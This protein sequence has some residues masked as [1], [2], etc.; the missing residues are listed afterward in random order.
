MTQTMLDIK[1]SGRQV[2]ALSCAF[3]PAEMK[4]RMT[5]MVTMNQLMSAM[6]LPLQK[7]QTHTLQEPL[8]LG[9]AYA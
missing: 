3:S 9:H 7:P 2:R 5:H 4:N 6:L 8:R 1:Q